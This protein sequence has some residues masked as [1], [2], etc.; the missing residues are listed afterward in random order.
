METALA[1]CIRQ[2]KIR[3][4]TIE[5]D[6]SHYSEVIG[7]LNRAW[8]QQSLKS[9]AFSTSSC[10]SS[11][12]EVVQKELHEN[13][14]K[15]IMQIESCQQVL[16]LNNNKIGLQSSEISQLKKENQQLSSQISLLE[17]YLAN[18]VA[19]SNKE[20]LQHRQLSQNEET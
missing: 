10:M 4:A 2:L 5:S 17:A 11:D 6:S 7:Q 9:S 14:Y 13:T 18:H 19:K 1:S 8:E 15:L 16:S 3:I 20:D 12:C